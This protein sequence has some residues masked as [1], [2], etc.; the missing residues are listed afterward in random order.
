ME[1][2][3]SIESYNYICEYYQSQHEEQL[4][5]TCHVDD[6]CED[7]SDTLGYFLITAINLLFTFFSFLSTC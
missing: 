7:N 2:V 5:F 4:R 6:Y 1:I 3:R